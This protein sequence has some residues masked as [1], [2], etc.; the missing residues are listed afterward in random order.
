VLK[1]E[2]FAVLFG[3]GITPWSRPVQDSAYVLWNGARHGEFHRRPC[4]RDIAEA[5]VVGK[6]LEMLQS[7]LPRI[8][9][10]HDGSQHVPAEVFSDGRRWSD[11]T[12]PLFNAAQT[13]NGARTGK[14]W[15]GLRVRPSVPPFLR[16]W[17][18]PSRSSN[19]HE[20]N[21]R[22]WLGLARSKRMTF[23]LLS[24][25]ANQ[26]ERNIQGVRPNC[27]SGSPRLVGPCPSETRRVPLI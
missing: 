20:F 19:K 23:V 18:P 1:F 13:A 10:L 5:D 8:T 16:P 26:A 7:A 9:I 15:K 11:S 4:F 14:P 6:P 24:R 25:A 21:L 2:D 3:R 12:P 22:W 17:W 27:A